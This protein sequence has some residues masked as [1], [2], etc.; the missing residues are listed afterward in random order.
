MILVDIIILSVSAIAHVFIFSQIY[1]SLFYGIPDVIRLKRKQ[2][3]NKDAHLLTYFLLILFWSSACFVLYKLLENNISKEWFESY[4]IGLVIAFFYSFKIFSKENR[5]L[6]YIDIMTNQKEYY[7]EII[8]DLFDLSSSVSNDVLNV[9]KNN[10]MYTSDVY[11]GNKKFFINVTMLNCLYFCLNFCINHNIIE[12]DKD[13]KYIITALLIK[14]SDMTNT[15][16]NFLSNCMYSIIDYNK[17]FIGKQIN[18]E[19]RTLY[20]LNY[21]ISMTPSNNKELIN[22]DDAIFDRYIDISNLFFAITLGENV[23]KCDNKGITLSMTSSVLNNALKTKKTTNK[24]E[25]IKEKIEKN[26]DEEQDYE[27]DEDLEEFNNSYE[28]EDIVEDDYEEDIDENDEFFK[29]EF[30]FSYAKVKEV[31]KKLGYDNYATFKK[32]VYNSK[33]IKRKKFEDKEEEVNYLIKALGYDD[34]E[35][36]YITNMENE[37]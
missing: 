2:I 16:Y 11:S 22:Q 10:E 4:L 9:I 21:L 19:F 34:F 14:L 3:L 23:D 5:M 24:K 27:Y 31:L 33:K 1:S 13:E 36:F 35:D 18:E 6:S 30:E 29:E 26:T 7:G 12:N 28:D 25:V 37:E 17:V 15:N 32:E 8:N 20:V